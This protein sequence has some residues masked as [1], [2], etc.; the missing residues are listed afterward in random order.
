MFYKASNF[1]KALDTWNT[2]NV[3]NMA[4]MFNGATVFNKTI[5]WN[6]AKVTTTAY[7][8]KSATAFNNNGNAGIDNWDVSKVT[9]MTEMF[10]QATNFNQPLNGWVVSSVTNMK[11]LFYEASNF[12]KDLDEWTVSQVTNMNGMFNKA[13]KFSKEINE[14]DIAKVSSSQIGIITD[15][16]T[17]SGHTN[18]L[19]KGSSKYYFDIYT[20]DIIN[21]TVLVEAI[22]EW[23]NES[24]RVEARGKYGGDIGEWDVTKVTDMSGLI[25]ST[26]YITSFNE[27]ISNWTVSQVTNMDSM[28]SNAQSFNQN[29]SGWD[30]SSVINM[31]YMFNQAYAFNQPLNTS[32][33]GWNTAKV[34]NMERM[35][36][37]ATSFNQPLNDWRTSN[38][39]YM[40]AMFSNATSFNNNIS[41][42]DVSNVANMEYMFSN[43]ILF[44]YDIS[45][46]DVSKLTYAP[47]LFSGATKFNRNISGWNVSNLTNMVGMFNAA[48]WFNQDLR[49]WKVEK[50]TRT[51][52]SSGAGNAGIYGQN[53][54]NHSDP[55][56]KSSSLSYFWIKGRPFTNS[57]LLT[58]VNEWILNSTTAEAKYNYIN[59]WN[60]SE[61]T[62]M[63]N[64]F[65]GKQFNEDISGWDVSK[66]S[67]MNG[68]FRNSP[69]NRD[70]SG[71]NVPNV[72]DMSYMFYTNSSFN[73]SLSSWTIT[74][75]ENMNS[76]FESATAF[77]GQ[78]NGWNTSKVKYMGSMFRNA[79]S[80]NQPLNNNWDVLSVTL[81]D[82]MF[83]GATSF[84]R[85][86]SDW[87]VSNVTNMNGMFNGA[88][89]FNQEI[90]EWN[91]AKVSSSGG[92]ITAF[93]LNSGHTND[94]FTGSSKYYFNINTVDISD[95]AA[96]VEA[97][98]QW[99]NESTRVEATGKYGGDIG[100]WD[101]SKVTDMSN[102]FKNNTTFNENISGWTVSKVT[103]M[104]SMFYNA[105]SFNQPLGWDVSKVTNMYA[106]F[107]QASSFNQ[108]LNSWNTGI[109]TNMQYMFQ[110]ATSFNNNISGWDVSSV[111][112]MNA[113]FKGATSFNRDISEWDVSSVINMREMFWNC[114]LFNQS[115]NDWVV[116]GVTDMTAMFYYAN[117]FNQPLNSWVVSKVSYM[118]NM[119]DSTPFN[120]SL[121][122][123]DV[124]K[125]SNMHG[126]FQ[127]NTA[128]NGNISDWDISKVTNINYMF[129]NATAFNQDITRWNVSKVSNYIQY[130]N[131]A[132]LMPTDFRNS[133]LY[134]YFKYQLA[135][136]S[137]LGSAINAWISNSS[138][139]EQTYGDPSNWDVSKVTD[140]T[141]L[142]EGSTF[143]GDISNW[144]VSNVTNM[145]D[146]FEGSTFNGDI[147][148]WDV[149]KVSNMQDMFK[150]STFNG[151][152]SN[153]DVSQVTTMESMFSGNTHFN[154]GGDSWKEEA[155]GVHGLRG[156]GGTDGTMTQTTDLWNSTSG[157]NLFYNSVTYE[158][159]GATNNNGGAQ[160]DIEYVQMQFPTAKTITHYKAWYG[161]YSNEHP[162]GFTI[163]G[164][165]DNGASFTTLDTRTGLTSWVESERDSDI[166]NRINCKSFDIPEN[167][168]GSYT[169]Y[170]IEMMTQFQYSGSGHIHTRISE[171]VLYSGKEGM[172]K[173]NVSNVKN[174][175]K[176]FQDASSFNQD[177]GGW[178]VSKVTTISN[179]FD[180]AAS[181][182]Q[183]ISFWPVW[184]VSSPGSYGIDSGHSDSTYFSSSDPSLTYFYAKG[185]PFSNADLQH[186][187][188]AWCSDST[189]AEDIFGDISDWNTSE[190]TDMEKLFRGKIFN[191]DISDWDVTNVTTIKQMFKE[192]T[193]NRNITDW[194]LVNVD[195][196][197]GLEEYGENSYHTDSLFTGSNKD[198]FN[199][200]QVSYPHQI[201]I[202]AGSSHGERHGTYIM[203]M[204]FKYRD[205]TLEYVAPS[206]GAKVSYNGSGYSAQRQVHNS[207]MWRSDGL[208]CFKRGGNNN[209]GW[210]DHQFFNYTLSGEL[211]SIYFMYHTG[212]DGWWGNGANSTA[213][214]FNWNPNI[215]YAE[216]EHHDYTA[217]HDAANY[218]GGGGYTFNG[219]F[220]YA[221]MEFNFENMQ[222]RLKHTF[223]YYGNFRSNL[224]GDGRDGAYPMYNYYLGAYPAVGETDANGNGSVWNNAGYPI[225]REGHRFAWPVN[226]GW[227]SDYSPA[228]ESLTWTAEDYR[229]NGQDWR[230]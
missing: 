157:Y 42:W 82:S 92:I 154:N 213:F 144:V 191:E 172:N 49:S 76:M 116:S 110:D 73:R 226:G 38:V 189:A 143:N 160:G 104:N 138:S 101:V 149:A 201:L 1:D 33:N 204:V 198:Y 102:L 167:N 13:S 55:L 215:T 136:S 94:L 122:D 196:T 46:W 84:N 52:T 224:Q 67:A 7:M 60:T 64:L 95:K 124:S 81:M 214:C 168:Q 155:G 31:S 127:T 91:I 9:D 77:N 156:T 108:S 15:F 100:V 5:N 74:K 174:M 27:N 137:A 59:N 12:N 54:N 221:K 89:K 63:N 48:S 207:N 229:T 50:I 146:M 145:K 56:F 47:Y 142:F 75:A 194:N 20:V 98:D 85:D 223:S 113:M 57:E 218:F 165:N 87:N 106:M 88:S 200:L 68:M 199:V 69:F 86:I 179:M 197:D 120:Q 65:N 61:V 182:D 166:E 164:S 228:W 209:E 19:F 130:G 111:T 121:N 203:N 28:F 78:I 51:G 96:L 133:N 131:N 23:L 107:F 40:Q 190:V 83:N 212:D 134:G 176:M 158:W 90:N 45:G 195:I 99:L 193:F 53:A 66:V 4:G 34:T 162:Y 184:N 181:F 128:F 6:T 114:Q 62:D 163:K 41:G 32:V 43:A 180:N 21:K 18:D 16:G 151:D 227:E 150:G 187:A 26:K 80:F 115:L 11:E 24:T 126:M 225:E 58:A 132:S 202:R 10:Y 112:L 36:R 185:R 71:W 205:G 139:A 39:T 25:G 230:Q 173:W 183:K 22:D 159:H 14:W 206:A 93:G 125:V 217:F 2:E 35:F 70:I 135:D 188:Q 103:N 8:F 192:S 170:R 109:V 147:S 222:H 140:M 29:I 216:Q 30:V 220:A 161:Y 186:A 105:Q 153:W 169:H 37:Y 141:G 211:D 72:V 208:V 148:N 219:L 3:S 177:I 117:S 79:T 152:I 171:V 17:N 178:N 210:H 97:I 119:F 118:T 44:N 129:K 175:K 123:W